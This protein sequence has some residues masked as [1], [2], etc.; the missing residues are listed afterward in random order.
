[1][2]ACFRIRNGLGKAAAYPAS[3]GPRGRIFESIFC[4][5]STLINFAYVMKSEQLS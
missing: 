2:I 3:G 1:M 5:F 4:E